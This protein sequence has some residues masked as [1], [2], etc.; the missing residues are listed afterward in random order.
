MLTIINDFDNALGQINI[1]VLMNDV[2]IIM[3][4]TEIGLPFL[5]KPDSTHFIGCN[6]PGTEFF[7][8]FIYEL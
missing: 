2:S 7:N 8:G 5:D 6:R 3:P 1:S 4:T